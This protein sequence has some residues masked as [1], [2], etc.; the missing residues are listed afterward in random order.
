M[1]KQQRMSV[2]GAIVIWGLL[3]ITF[4]V[5]AIILINLFSR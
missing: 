1:A 4:I 2:P 3:A 5:Q